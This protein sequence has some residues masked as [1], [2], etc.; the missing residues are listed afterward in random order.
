MGL[1]R[2]KTLE[3][4]KQ[5]LFYGNYITQ[6]EGLKNG[7]LDAGIK[8]AD[9]TTPT[10]NE[11]TSLLVKIRKI[12]E[13]TELDDTKK[14]YVHKTKEMLLDEWLQANGFIKS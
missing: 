8:K 13:K 5:Y 9:G 7:L 14:Y 12:E 6:A 11:L 10:A 4:V 2:G 3:T 1:D